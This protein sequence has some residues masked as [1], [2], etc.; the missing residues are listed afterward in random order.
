MSW[1]DRLNGKA[2]SCLEKIAGFALVCVTIL[3]GSDIVGRLLG[4]PI[5]GTF[6]IV[7]FSGGIV[8]G[9]A[10][11]V[12]SR[13]KSHVGVDFLLE[14]VP[15]RVRSVLE[16]FNRLLGIMLIMLLAYSLTRIG[17]DLRVAGEVS[18][19]IH[20]PFYPVA[21][22]VTVALVIEVFVLIGD[23]LRIGGSNNE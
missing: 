12:A 7:S 3:T 5:P 6:E 8:V 16:V 17:N 9:L 14:I 18:P 19:V 10:I 1:L 23:L 20:V 15:A 4:M 2:C 13:A 11:P 22:G 21:Y